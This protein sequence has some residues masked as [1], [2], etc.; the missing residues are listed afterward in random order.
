MTQAE[1]LE[2]MKQWA[3][4]ERM[5]PEAFVGGASNINSHFIHWQRAAELINEGDRVLEAGCGCGLPARIYSLKSRR[6]VWAVDQE[7]AVQWARVL[8]PTPGVH[9]RVGDFNN[10]DWLVGLGPFDVVVCIDVLEH[11]REKDVF[12]QALADMSHEGTRYI[13]SV[14]ITLIPEEDT[15]PWHVHHWQTEE[16]FLADVGRILPAER[17]TR[18]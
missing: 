2:G 3:D 5:V 4:G 16:E 14:P 15:S 8:Y 12:L 9:F 11:V 17:V 7:Y 10:R 18:I 6:P 1:Y 13:L